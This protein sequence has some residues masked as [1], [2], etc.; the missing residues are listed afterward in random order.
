MQ[1][2]FPTPL[3]HRAVLAR[4]ALLALLLTNVAARAADDGFAPFWKAFQGEVARNSADGVQRLTRLP[5]LFEN[6]ERGAA[7]FGAV[8]RALF[9]PK[10]RACIAK[11]RPMAEDDGYVVFCTPASF[12]FRRERDAWRFVEF[13]ADGED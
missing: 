8:Y 11:A 2:P 5:I 9:T 12:Y 7:E 10:V 4:A 3:S 13:G 6:K 1:S